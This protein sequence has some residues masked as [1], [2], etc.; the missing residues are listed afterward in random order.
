MQ[1]QFNVIV[2]NL[3]TTLE[4][5]GAGEILEMKSGELSVNTELID[6]DLYRLLN[7]DV[8]GSERLPRRIYEHLSLGE[9]DIGI[10]RNVRQKIKAIPHKDSAADAPAQSLRSRVSFGN[11]YHSDRCYT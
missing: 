3:K 2:H 5:N 4:E 6:Y 10:Y 11:N 8:G 1:K 7:G 9:Y